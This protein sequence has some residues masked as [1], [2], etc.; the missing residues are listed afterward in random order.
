MFLSLIT[1]A[2]ALGLSV[3]AAYYSIAGLA[4]IFA[5]AMLPIIIMGSVLELAKVVVTLWLHEYWSRCRL[6]MKL[7]LVPAVCM[8]MLITSMGIFGFLS[9]AHSDQTL[10]SGDAQGKIAIYDEKIKTAKENIEADRKQLKQMDEAVDQVMARST[11]EEGASK[12]NAIRRSQARDRTALAKSIEANQK[13]IGIL[14]EEAAPI[15]AEIRKIEAEVGPIKYI[16]ALIYGDNTDT[17][18]LERSVRWVIILL[19][20]VFDPLAIMMLLAATESLRWARKPTATEIDEKIPKTSWSDTVA[21]NTPTDTPVDIPSSDPTLD[22]CYKCGT[23]LINAPGIGPFCPNRA[24]DVLDGPFL[25][26]QEPVQIKVILP[27]TQVDEDHDENDTVDLKHAKEQWKADNPNDTLKRHRRLLELGVIDQLPWM[28]YLPR[29]PES[30]FGSL[31]P[32]KGNKGDTFISTIGIPHKL[33]KHN[34]S[35]WISIDSTQQNNYTYDIAY[36]DH[37]I[38]QIEQGRYDPDQLSD[39]ERDQIEQRIT[40][41]K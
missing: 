9:K 7:Y 17:D 2:V 27:T 8:L 20:C 10:I 3:I 30:G 40:Q 24:C 11:T 25:N 19:V 38:K 35:A 26:D 29:V 1:L 12:S 14:N 15:R 39:S 5:A 36:I 32:E 22:P 13:L 6:L 23:P 18:V 16:A 37:L 41:T 28:K 33:Y 21:D 31:L 4:T 34:G